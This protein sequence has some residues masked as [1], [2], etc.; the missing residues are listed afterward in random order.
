[1]ADVRFENPRS[2]EE[3]GFR[4]DMTIVRFTHGITSVHQTVCVSNDIAVHALE[5]DVQL[6][7]AWAKAASESHARPSIVLDAIGGVRVK[8]RLKHDN[9]RATG[10]FRI[11]FARACGEVWRY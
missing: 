3:N 1:M 5:V 10:P 2:G 8:A 6:G 11:N 7:P 4:G 9:P